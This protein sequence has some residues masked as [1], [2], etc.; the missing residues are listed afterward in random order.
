MAVGAG[1]PELKLSV[2]F[3]LAY[4]R[5]QL[6]T[7]GKVA[8]SYYLP[9]NIKFDRLG[10]QNEFTKL[11]KNIS[12]RQYNLKVEIKSLE[13]ALKQAKELQQ[14]LNETRGRSA[15][16]TTLQ[17]LTGR[18]NSGK[19]VLKAD[20]IRNVYSAAMKAGVEGLSGNV[21]ANRSVLEKE[22]K[23]AFGS[24]SDNALKGLINGLINGEGGLKKAASSL[25]DSLINEL[26]K[27]LEIRSPS[28]RT[29]RIGEQSDEG[30]WIGLS[31]NAVKWERKKAAEM[32]ASIDRIYK[33]IQAS[34]GQGLLDIGVTGGALVKW[35][36]D[37]AKSTRQAVGGAIV[38]ALRDGLKGG[39][40]AGVAA[41]FQGAG[42]VATGGAFTAGA[43][44]G[45]GKGG[46]A[47]LSALTSGGL[48]PGLVGRVTEAMSQVSHAVVV[49]GAEAA[50]I[51]AAGV[52]AVAGAGAFASTATGS[53]ITQAVEAV[54]NSTVKKVAVRVLE[55]GKALAEKGK[56]DIAG[57]K[58]GS[59]LALFRET[60][61][62]ILR[63]AGEQARNEAK[64]LG[65]EA[66]RGIAAGGKM[67][68]AGFVAG[69]QLTL[70]QSLAALDRGIKFLDSILIK[71]AIDLQGLPDGTTIAALKQAFIGY[72]AAL[73]IGATHIQ[74]AGEIDQAGVRKMLRGQVDRANGAPI[75]SFI[76]THVQDLGNAKSGSET[77]RAIQEGLDAIAAA[78]AEA[79]RQALN[80]QARAIANANRAVQVRDLGNTGRAL[81]PGMSPP[82]LPPSG[83]SRYR[84][85]GGFVPPSGIP[86][87]GPA[88]LNPRT[89]LEAHQRLMAVV[90]ASVR[91]TRELTAA[92]LPL[93]GGLRELGGEFANAAKQVLLYGTA[94]KALAFATALP[95]QLLDATK[96]FQQYSNA[97]GVA[98]QGTGNFAK[99]MFFVDTI[100]KQFGLN[101][102]TTRAGFTRL[103][104]SMAPA[105]FDS[106]SIEKLFTGI[107]AATA[108]LQLTP[109]AAERVTYAFGQIASKGQVMSEEVKG[110]L[111]DVLP[112]AL[113]IF[114]KAAG[115]S[116]QE[117]NKNMEDG[118][119]KGEK[120]RQ[121]MSSVSDELITRFGTGAQIAG[122][123]LQ[124]LLN[125]MGGNF[126]RVLE[127]FAPLANSAAESILLPISNAMNQFGKAAQVAMGEAAL[128]KRQ[129]DQAKENGAS[130]Q[131]IAA[132]ETRLQALNEAAADPAIAKQAGQ[133]KS[134]IAELSKL[135]NILTGVATT[136]GGI[137]SPI[138]S[139][140]GTNLSTVA[141]IVTSV[142]L[143]LGA[144]RLTATLA[145][146]A[147]T[148][149][150]VMMRAASGQAIGVTALSGAFRGLGVSIT[151]SEIATIGFTAAMK[152]LLAS[153]VIGLLVVGVGMLASA[154]MN[155]GDK[156]S[157]A[158]EKTKAAMEGIAD[159]ARTG[160]VALNAMQAKTAQVNIEN[161]TLAKKEIEKMSFGRF[162]KAMLN[163]TQIGKINLLTGLE[164]KPGEIQDKKDLLKTIQSQINGYQGLKK[165]AVELAPF[166]KSQEKRL[167][168]NQPNLPAANAAELA[169]GK[170]KKTSLESYYSLEDSLAKARTEADID[171]IT[172]EFEHRKNMIN[173][174]Y[175]L[176]DARANSFQKETLKFQREMF[177]IE[178]ERQKTVLEA[179][180]AVRKASGSVAG[181]VSG[182]GISQY[183]TGDKSSANYDAKHGGSNYHDHFAFSTR[184]AA[185]A[186]YEALKMAG[187][188]VTELTG[189]G[190]GVTGPHSGP[191]SLHH[192]GLAFDVPGSQWAVGQEQA[193]SA[194]VRS[195]VMGQGGAG[196]VRKVGGNEKR[197]IQAELQ[198]QIELQKK[199]TAS[200]NADEIAIR[201]QQIAMENYLA[202]MMPMAEQQVQNQLL[203]RRIALQAAGTPDIVIDREMQ[204][205][206]A[207][208]QNATAIGIHTDK[209]KELSKQKDKN[210]VIT[211]DAARQIALEQEAIDKLIARYPV[212]KAL[213]QQ[214]GN[215][216]AQSGF[217]KDIGSLRNQIQLA[218]IIDPQAELRQK[219]IREGRTSD[220]AD[221]QVKL[222]SQLDFLTKL[223]DGYRGVADAIGNSFGEAFKGIVSGSMT[224][225]QAL[226]GMFQSIADSF[227]D[228]V[229]QMISSWIQAQAVKGFQAIFGAVLSGF[230]G[231]IG[232]GF[233]GGGGGGFNFPTTTGEGTNF[234]PNIGNDTGIPWQFANGGIAQGG[235][236]AFASG[237]IVTGPTLGLVGEGRYN[238]AVIPLPDGKSVPVD[239]G[240]MGGAGNQI[241]S[242]IVVN[243]NSDGQSQSQQSGNGNAELG[244]KIEG[245]VKQVIVGELRPGG[246]LAGRR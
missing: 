152:T 81:P 125:T 245:A 13:T 177:N 17:R 190:A 209:I 45:L 68:G 120:F 155:M 162:G 80:N 220:Q 129:L 197:D 132:L 151:A 41:P 56:T 107:S 173:T 148:V 201:K 3:D 27:T 179:T 174:Y 166:T 214:S 183:L 2:G 135:G 73:E 21:K 40:T 106:G 184:E 6:P 58:D 87:D 111:G 113:S 114:A 99:E 145:T 146:A 83:G 207:E 233:T 61:T 210:N 115:V 69:G 48:D 71:G 157:A 137:L 118:M 7:L 126:T 229:A 8:S 238:E 43:T 49:N 194:R 63:G 119:Y 138:L 140:L 5:T 101:L 28:K 188:T 54:A 153:S 92:N 246:L 215:L 176:Q 79:A 216:Q 39:I 181:G 95:G 15:R 24:A 133:I 239:L 139:I 237:G 53:L 64:A 36:R 232:G 112:G 170:T 178:A 221:E 22:L 66:G 218:G 202:A 44:A 124:G 35:E 57:L 156:A 89:N 62:A 42:L 198:T 171:R 38:Q 180:N 12:G 230:G 65:R 85:G 25:G 94:Y 29:E 19:V 14:I 141:S 51:T 70:Q 163:D 37:L 23:T 98:T 1:S 131:S 193:G 167:G 46:M 195:I 241:T 96:K 109:D 244:K 159:A 242:N 217:A 77:N 76:G 213:L 234:S 4:F 228:M 189:R 78:A 103:Y 67:A 224:A 102:E 34:G 33:S 91:S 196:P 59:T 108:A 243:V 187:V 74:A 123:S 88:T 186:A 150:N 136:I 16:S 104:A 154:M 143:G 160:N 147:L 191:G 172:A 212:Y 105:N 10:I 203:E 55:A 26:K 84:Y 161:A 208:L 200:K 75:S 127:S 158:A 52:A 236:R 240:G 97:M 116:V 223:R 20:D 18:D 231:G 204:L 192:S 206:E 235:F 50:V 226:A 130:S 11:G 175:D 144:M 168:Q 31:K 149:M 60:T 165:A 199:S 142:A 211:A 122:K 100:Q 121:L 110:Q 32:R 82:A 185:L 90:N 9:I 128:V 86:S 117:F 182:G 227:L 225:Q 169:S 134:F 93:V 222:Q 219:L 164:I 30:F 72:R 205:Y 47:A